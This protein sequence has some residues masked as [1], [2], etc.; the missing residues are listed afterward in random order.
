MLVITDN[1]GGICLIENELMRK[2]WHPPRRMITQQAA[3]RAD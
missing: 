2:A 3:L 1:E